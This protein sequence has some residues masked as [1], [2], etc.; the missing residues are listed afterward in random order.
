MLSNRKRLILKAVIENYSKEVKPIGSD[1]LSKI[2]YLKFSSATIRYDMLQLEEK[3]Y[4]I[5]NHKSSGRIPSLKGYVFYLNNLMTRKPETKEILT[6]FEKIIQKKNLNKEKIV[7]EV[8]K[9]LCNLTNHAII[10]IKPDILKTSKIK[11]IDL[12]FVNPRQAVIFVLTNKGHLQH[13]NIFLDEDKE[14]KVEDLKIIVNIFNNLLINKYLNEALQIIQS[15]LCQEQIKKH[16]KYQEEL[17]QFF[18]EAFY[19][20]YNNNTSFYGISNFLTSQTEQEIINI[21]DIYE[22]LNTK[23]LI[24]FFYDSKEV[25]CKLANQIRL[26][27]Y[28]KFIFV[29]IPYNISE[30]EKG[31]IAVLGFNVIKYSEIIPI[32]EYLSAHISH[33]YE[34][35]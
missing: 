13:Q 2:P 30:N 18:L 33:L 21:K 14:F 29:S 4:L 26:I 35:K 9:L 23:K 32:L 24:N 8:L 11:K 34:K 1:F 17:I 3:G 19:K 28:K 5:K 22:I 15:D 7:Q 27:P 20:F 6:L 12:I 16:I 10:D 25:I 31:F